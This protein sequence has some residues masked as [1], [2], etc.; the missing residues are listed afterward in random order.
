MTVGT[1]ASDC[2]LNVVVTCFAAASAIHGLDLFEEGRQSARRREI[3]QLD[4]RGVEAC[5]QPIVH[6]F[7]GRLLAFVVRCGVWIRAADRSWLEESWR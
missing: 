1:I 7:Q 5:P 3:A 4:E 6:A 2:T